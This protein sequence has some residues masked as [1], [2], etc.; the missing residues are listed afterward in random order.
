MSEDIKKVDA[1]SQETDLDAVMRKY[2]RE[3]N[4]RIW[5]GTPALIIKILAA[6][7]SLYCIYMTLWSHAITEVRLPLFLGFILILGFL[8]GVLITVSE[9][10]LQVLAQQVQAI[11]NMAMILTVAVPVGIG[12]AEIRL[13]RRKANYIR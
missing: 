11:P 5:R 4:T 8:L 7:F 10:D 9:P 6:V 3:S 12:L 2:D 1:A 13:E